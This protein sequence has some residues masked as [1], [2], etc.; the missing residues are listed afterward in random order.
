MSLEVHPL[1]PD[2]WD[3]LVV[4]FDRPGDARG[5]WC[6]WWRVRA[7]EFDRLGG[8]GTRDAFHQVVLA[9]PPP[10]L[11]AYRDAHPVGWCAVAPREQ[12][13]RILRSPVLRPADDAP[14][15]WA[16]V[17]FYVEKAERGGGVATALLDAA[18]EFAA[19]SGAEAVEG[20]PKDT[21]GG[22]RR[23]NELFVGSTAMFRRAGFREVG[24]RSPTRPIMRRAIGGRGGRAGSR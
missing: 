23:A 6:M 14:P 18:V 15:C 19:A 5:C 7:S 24:R 21:A 9:G 1:T 4:L 3:D 22:R 10:G 16:V 17:C 13:P 8:Q 12:F 2:R 11:L 20:Y